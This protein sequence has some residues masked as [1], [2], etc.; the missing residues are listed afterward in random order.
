MKKILIGSGILSVV[1]ILSLLLFF[2]HFHSS[3]PSELNNPE[4]S[5]DSLNNANN[6]LTKGAGRRTLGLPAPQ[7]KRMTP[8]NQSMD[9]HHQR[10][11]SLE[12][13][14]SAEDLHDVMFVADIMAEI[15]DA[16]IPTKDELIE[17]TQKKG[18]TPYEERQ[19]HEKTGFRQVV[20]IN[21]LKDDNRIIREFY[22]SYYEHG[23]QLAFDRFYYGLEKKEYLFEQLVRELD[24]RIDGNYTKRIIRKSKARWDFGD[25]SFIFIHDDYYQD[26][27]SNKKMILIGK[28][29]EIH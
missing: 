1:G 26:G 4:P 19:G 8:Q 28:E 6:Q 24:Q 2:H 16:G 13:S 18:Y 5:T 10:L 11:P 20:R 7:K 12:D 15:T 17:Y 21:E 14:F 22:G 9:Q 29:W 23:D 25:S 27:D 3:S